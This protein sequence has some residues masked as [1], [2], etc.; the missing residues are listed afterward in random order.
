MLCTDDDDDDYDVGK[1]AKI[2]RCM[3]KIESP[4]NIYLAM[5]IISVFFPFCLLF[6]FQINSNCIKY[7]IF[8]VIILLFSII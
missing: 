7:H 3:K 5:R 8:A 4:K 2:N 1:M 6:R